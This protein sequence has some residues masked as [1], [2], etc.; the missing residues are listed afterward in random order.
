MRSGSQWGFP[1]LNKG[2][3]NR[4]LDST[5]EGSYGNWAEWHHYSVANC[6]HCNLVVV[7]QP[8]KKWYCKKK[9]AIKLWKKNKKMCIK[10][11]SVTVV[12]EQPAVTQF[13]LIGT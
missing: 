10:I 9:K 8:H 6:S 3:K 5:T 12:K 1:W 4:V 7:A 13:F 11:C 2:K